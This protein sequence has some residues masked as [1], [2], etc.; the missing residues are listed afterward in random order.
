VRPGKSLNHAHLKILPPNVARK[1]G[2]A[3]AIPRFASGFQIARLVL[4][5]LKKG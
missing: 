2:A 4:I 3:I 5:E 1:I